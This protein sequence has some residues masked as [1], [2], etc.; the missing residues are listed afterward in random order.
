MMAK[1]NA[2]VNVSRINRIKVVLVEQNKTGKW[3]SEQLQRNEATI[4]RW[5]SNA[6]QPSL[7][8]L[9]KIADIFK[10][11]VRQLINGINEK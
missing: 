9:V 10:V 11:D 8:M 4:S 3:L 5:C 7:E 1:S 2:K 6:S